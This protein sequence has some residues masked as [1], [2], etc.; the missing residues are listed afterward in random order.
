VNQFAGDASPRNIVAIGASAGGIGV[1]VELARG[2]PENFPASI[3]VVQHL[4]ASSPSALPELLSRAGPLKAV[5]PK[6]EN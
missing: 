2:L 3:F 5:H 6:M 4:P 1:L